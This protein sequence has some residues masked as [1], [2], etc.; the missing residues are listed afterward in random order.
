MSV[1][2]TSFANSGQNVLKKNAH[3]PIGGQIVKCFI[4]VSTGIVLVDITVLRL[5]FFANSIFNF[6]IRDY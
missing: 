4:M 6:I 5:L 3:K 2:Y 1:H